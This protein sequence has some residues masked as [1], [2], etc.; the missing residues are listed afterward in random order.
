[1][2]NNVMTPVTDW[3]HAA[4]FVRNTLCFNTRRD[5]AQEVRL[6]AAWACKPASAVTLGDLL[7]YR[8]HLESR[9]LKP[10]TIAKK[11]TVL[12]RLFGFLAEQGVLPR[13]P[14]AGLK[15]PAVKDEASKDILTLEECNRLIGSIEAQTLRD[16]RDRAILALLLING[17]RICEIC[18]ANIGDLRQ[19]E[20]CW[21]LRV[22]GKGGKEADTRIREDVLATIHTY[23]E[24][25]RETNPDAPLFIGT[26]HRAGARLITRTMQH[27][28]MG[29]LEVAGISRPNLTVHSLRHTAVTLVIMSGASLIHA[30][31][32]ARHSDP[33]TTQRYF[34]NFE[35]LKSHAVMLH[36][37][38]VQTSA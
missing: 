26:N 28:V 29:R 23:L 19:T 2:Q 1:M 16:K 17:L 36:P 33:K 31:E 32:F 25:R 27:M 3:Q 35:R 15:L 8:E 9:G 10:A 34:H 11:L 13:N 5:Y 24:E 6:F 37:L 14:S 20:G 38:T 30:Q 12:R 21:V 7:S 22:H 18:R 4:A